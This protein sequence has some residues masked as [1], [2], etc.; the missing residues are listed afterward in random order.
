MYIP[1]EGD[2]MTVCCENLVALSLYD[3][4]NVATLT[5]K[6]T[7]AHGSGIFDVGRSQYTTTYRPISR[8]YAR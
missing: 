3:A 4:V 8:T 5:T 7:S 1:T 2:T 6:M